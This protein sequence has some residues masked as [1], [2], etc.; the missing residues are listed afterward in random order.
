MND[1]VKTIALTFSYNDPDDNEFSLSKTV[2][3]PSTDET[4]LITLLETFTK[5]LQLSGFEYVKDLKVGIDED[6]LTKTIVK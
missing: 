6:T 5:F 3:L 4:G 1:E 2:D